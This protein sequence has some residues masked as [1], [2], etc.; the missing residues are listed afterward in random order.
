MAVIP[1]VEIK[2]R[3][4]LSV[5]DPQSLVITPLFDEEKAFSPDSIDLRLGSRF[6]LPQV[7]PQ[8]FLTVDSE[9]TM[10][11]H[12]RVH[13]PWGKYLVVPAHQTVLGATLE[14]IK[15]PVDL[16][17]QILTK[18]SI[19][20]IFII[21]ET[22]PWVHPSYRGCLTLEI[23]NVSNT[24]LLLHPGIPIGQLILQSVEMESVPKEDT[25]L[26]GSYLGPVYP[27][28]PKFGKLADA[29]QKIGISKIDLPRV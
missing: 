19:A 8:P 3:M 10:S 21:I 24:P 18:S 16:S 7:P 4:G 1:A 27:E 23:A 22:A 15:I 20:R 5:K 25:N 13:V 28:P 26:S 11:A 14:F 9:S 29:M 2:R 6:L 17:A 12:L